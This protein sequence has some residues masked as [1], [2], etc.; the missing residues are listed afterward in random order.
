MLSDLFTEPTETAV[1]K[2]KELFGASEPFIEEKNSFDGTTRI[3]SEHFITAVI[4][5][6]TTGCMARMDR[7]EERLFYD[8]V[9]YCNGSN[10]RD[11]TSTVNGVSSDLDDW[12]AKLIR[13]EPLPVVNGCFDSGF[14]PQIYTKDN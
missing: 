4:E 5:A 3:F 2:A 9:K 14:V 12:L 7:N 13:E 8:Y 6:L 10:Y 11:I 1:S